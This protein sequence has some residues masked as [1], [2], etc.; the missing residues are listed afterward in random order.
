MMLDFF[1]HLRMIK[2]NLVLLIFHVEQ[3]SYLYPTYTYMGVGRRWLVQGKDIKS[4]EIK[5]IGI[6]AL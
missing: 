3:K 1:A 6:K 2:V 5:I 4:L